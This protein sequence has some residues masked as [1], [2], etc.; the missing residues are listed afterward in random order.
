MPLS[1]FFHSPVLHLSC[2]SN[3]IY[4]CVLWS[5]SPPSFLPILYI[6]TFS[7]YLNQNLL[8]EEDNEKISVVLG[9]MLF[10]HALCSTY[11]TDHTQQF[12]KRM[13]V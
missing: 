5:S 9:I 4:L 6:R 3:P 12:W 1:H 13:R 10:K 11:T 8:L 2:L 7:V